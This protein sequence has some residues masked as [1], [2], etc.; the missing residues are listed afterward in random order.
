MTRPPM[1]HDNSQLIDTGL[2]NILSVHIP[3]VIFGISIMFLLYWIANN[4]IKKSNIKKI[5]KKCAIASY[6]VYLF[7]GFTVGFFNSYA[8]LLVGIP[9]LFFVFYYVQI[10]YNKIISYLFPKRDNLAIKFIH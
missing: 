5:I 7:H 6:P 8:A 3:K 1:L 10:E 9:I 2:T 4:Y